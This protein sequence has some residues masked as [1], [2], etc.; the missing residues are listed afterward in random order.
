MNTYYH[1]KG[2]RQVSKT[3]PLVAKVKEWVDAEYEGGRVTA[4]TDE[5][6]EVVIDRVCQELGV[7][8]VEGEQ[9]E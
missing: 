1:L 5:E 2:D 3:S 6:L 8:I 9:T 7:T 4:I